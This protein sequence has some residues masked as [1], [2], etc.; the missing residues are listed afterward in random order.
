FVSMGG[1]DSVGTGTWSQNVSGFTVG[2]RYTLSFMLAGEDTGLFW[3]VTAEI[4]DTSIQSQNFQ[5]PPSSA[6]YWRNWQTF[7]MT[8]T[9][10]A[11][12]EQVFFTSTTQFDVG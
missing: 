5:A 1:G 6:T 4:I 7:N 9:A 10:N 3:P 12:T 2:L 11:A 8:F